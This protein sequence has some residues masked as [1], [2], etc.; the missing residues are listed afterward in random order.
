MSVPLKSSARLNIPVLPKG[1]PHPEHHLGSAKDPH[2]VRL[3][4]EPHPDP[5]GALGANHP[6]P[7]MLVR[8][9]ELYE[10]IPDRDYRENLYESP[11]PHRALLL[12]FLCTTKSLPSL[13]YAEG[14]RLPLSHVNPE[15]TRRAAWRSGPGYRGP[16]A[17]QPPQ[18]AGKRHRCR[19]DSATRSRKHSPMG[20]QMRLQ[21]RLQMGSRMG[22]Q[23]RSP[24]ES[25]SH[26]LRT[27]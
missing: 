4:N 24:R 3:F 5:T 14:R 22:S 17:L 1:Q 27:P 20:L 7:R 8:S 21:T 18:V 23:R 10:P 19:A 15:A 9:Q 25:S 26:R 2:E 12:V 6:Q 11:L 16:Q 13:F